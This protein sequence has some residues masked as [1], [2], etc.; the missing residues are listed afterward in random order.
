MEHVLSI[1]SFLK[2]KKYESNDEKYILLVRIILLEPGTFLDKPEMGLGIVSRYRFG[3]DEDIEK[4]KTDLNNQIS[5]YLP[6]FENVEIVVTPFGNNINIGI[7]VN[8][9]EYNFNFNK[10]T[11]KLEDLMKGE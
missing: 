10:E 2:P 8:N 1:D 3:F 6:T 11:L 9:L 7:R 5:T 4:L